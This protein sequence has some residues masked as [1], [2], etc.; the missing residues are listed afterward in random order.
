[1]HG[2][3]S[4]YESTKVEYMSKR[5]RIEEK[6]KP[7]NGPPRKKRKKEEVV[8]VE[9]K[10]KRSEA[11]VRKEMLGKGALLLRFTVDRENLRKE[12]IDRWRAVE[13][14]GFL[15]T[16]KGCLIPAACH[17]FSNRS[18]KVGYDCALSFF[19]GQTRDPDSDGRVDGNGW[20]C[21]DVVS[22]LCHRNKCCAYE[23][24]EMSP[25][26][27]NFK[28]NYCGAD[29]K[30]DCG[31]KPPCVATYHPP[32]FVGGPLDL[33]AYDTPNLSEKIK[34]LFERDEPGYKVKVSILPKDEYKTQ[35]LK[36]DN[37]NKRIKGS[38]KTAKE[39][40]KKQSRM[41]RNLD[42][43]QDCVNKT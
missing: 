13:K 27:K 17:W 32:N 5:K 26:W 25:R 12:E 11:D 22:H 19:K 31:L 24:L 36:R 38:K 10:T 41:T 8:V 2:L 40:K 15:V 37:R 29:G 30:C 3:R 23:H 16:A 4:Q 43:S 33:L 34:E 6:K 14:K 42:N 20:D 7:Q 35:D 9:R 28:R 21:A 1:L 39:T 18:K